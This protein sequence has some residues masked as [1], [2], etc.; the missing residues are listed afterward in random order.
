MA[1]GGSEVRF[2][3]TSLDMLSKC[4]V[5]WEFRY[6]KGLSRP[7]GVAMLVGTAVDHAANA[8]LQSKIDTG[9]L[10][11]VEE[12]GEIAVEKLAKEW[13]HGVA[14]SDE[15]AFF[16]PKAVKG[17]ATDR[18]AALAQAHTMLLA[19]RIA[20]QRLQWEW[21]LE[22]E[23]SDTFITGVVDCEEVDGSIRDLKT[24]GRKP[25][26]AM[27]DDSTQLSLYA[28]AK[29]VIDGQPAPV[30][31]RLDYLVASE[32]HLSPWTVGLVTFESSRTEA[33]F[34]QITRRVERAIHVIRS[35]A[36]MPARPDDWWCSSK[37]C[38]YWDVCPFARRPVAVALSRA[39][40]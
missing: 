36:F 19:P 1:E 23:G 21:E 39:G 14:L 20:P 5:M 15:D 33:D 13:D 6:V 25:K 26:E 24:T 34:D 28:L 9:S 30:G 17:K 8:T 18:A 37:W 11:S 31:V 29:H 10:L 32:G 7:P 3:T 35:G 40:E 38:G 4:G 22:V 2:R 12:V 16:G 27:A